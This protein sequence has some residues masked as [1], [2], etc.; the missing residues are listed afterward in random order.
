MNRLFSSALLQGGGEVPEGHYQAEN[1]KQTVVPFRNA[2]MLSIACGFAESAGAGGLVIAA[3]EGDHVIYPDCREDFMR[4]MGE[5]MRLGTYAGVTLLRPFIAMNKGEIAATGVRLGVDF[6]RTWSL[7][8]RPPLRQMR[9]LRGAKRSVCKL[10]AGSD[11]VCVASA[12]GQ[13]ERTENEN[14]NGSGSKGTVL[15]RNH[16][17]SSIP[18]IIS[19]ISTRSRRRPAHR[20]P[21]VCAHERVR[22][23]AWCDT[24]TPRGTRHL[25][26]RGQILAEI[27]TTATR[28]VVLTGGCR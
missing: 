4:A 7:W 2:I 22:L 1:M 20:V 12:A 14:E 21:S 9:H 3:H 13:P 10:A 8:R 17:R 15:V 28:H 23:A 6:A 24:P 18:D 11:R 26:Q 16:S 5:A 19:E 27:E 25:A